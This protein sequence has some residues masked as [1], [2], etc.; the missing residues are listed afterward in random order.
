MRF[1]YYKIL[2][3]TSHVGTPLKKNLLLQGSITHQTYIGYIERVAFYYKIDWNPLF[4]GSYI[5]ALVF[6][7]GG[8]VHLLNTKK[9][10]TGVFKG[11]FEN[12]QK[13]EIQRLSKDGKEF[14]LEKVFFYKDDPTRWIKAFIGASEPG[15]FGEAFLS[16]E[17]GLLARRPLPKTKFQSKKKNPL[18]AFEQGPRFFRARPEGPKGNHSKISQKIRPFFL[19]KKNLHSDFS[20]K[21][22]K[23]K[24]KKFYRQ[25]N[26]YL[27]ESPKR[28]PIITIHDSGFLPGSISNWMEHVRFSNQYRSIP[29]KY[30][31]F[32]SQYKKLFE[33]FIRLKNQSI[34][35]FSAEKTNGKNANPI[36]KKKPDII[37]VLNSGK[38][39]GILFESFRESLPVFGAITTFTKKE[40]VDFPFDGNDTSL[41]SME[42]WCRWITKIFQYVQIR[43]FKKKTVFLKNAF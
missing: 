34:G 27:P 18:R 6:L 31:L 1:E 33:D 9:E 40:W 11:F 38:E 20:K 43:R 8:H 16:S 17:K 5:L 14:L 19:K 10:W 29:E 7:Y 22:Y 30:I 25:K 28:R 41:Y 21:I 12:F 26:L 32:F 36:L 15:A 2:K 37:M 3:T 24:K 39:Y 23:E 4:F 35:V 13:K 42:I